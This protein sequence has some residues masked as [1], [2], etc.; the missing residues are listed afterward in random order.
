MIRMILIALLALI[1][2]VLALAATRP[3]AFRVERSMRIGAPPEKIL[4][5]IPRA[6][7]RI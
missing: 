2:A 6:P 3:G 4:P 7:A 1:A 5:L